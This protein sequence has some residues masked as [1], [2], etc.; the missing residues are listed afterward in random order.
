EDYEKNK[1]LSSAFVEQLTQQTSD[2][3]NAWLKARNENNYSLYQEE[4]GKM[5]ALKQQQAEMYGYQAHP[6]DALVDDYEKGMTVAVL[7]P[8]FNK[9]K[10][11]LPPLLKRITEAQQVDDSFFYKNFPRQQQW[12][13]SIDVLKKMGYDFEAGRQDISEH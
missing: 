13:F 10:E 9:V 12:D 6:Y 7:D 2:S 1:K 5:L 11:Q 8:I 3:F 4:L